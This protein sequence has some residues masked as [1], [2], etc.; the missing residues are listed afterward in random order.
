[1]RGCARRA[2]SVC[3]RWRGLREL[4]EDEASCW[5]PLTSQ[6]EIPATRCIAQGWAG[7]GLG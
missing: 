3:R 5:A 7:T 1:V 4:R 2:Y 6:S